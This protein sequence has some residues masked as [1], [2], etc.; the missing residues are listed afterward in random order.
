MNTH[1]DGY[2]FRQHG[3]S[4]FLSWCLTHVDV[5]YCV[6]VTKNFKTKVTMTTTQQGSE[7]SATYSKLV[8][9]SCRTK[10]RLVTTHW[11]VQHC[12]AHVTNPLSDRS[13]VA[14][15]VVLHEQQCW[16]VCV[17]AARVFFVLVMVLNTCWRL[18]L[19][20]CD[21]DGLDTSDNG[22]DLAARF[23]L[24]TEL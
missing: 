8:P 21:Q 2:V 3:C 23:V 22:H 17:R 18:V 16:L 15:H 11:H 7:D 6:L 24:M 20:V 14:R 4:L 1:V 19:R 5:E 9:K 10:T 12:D 13:R